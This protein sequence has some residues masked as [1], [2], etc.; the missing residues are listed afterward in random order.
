MRGIKVS[1][2]HGVN[3]MITVCFFCGKDKNEI[4][5]LGRLPGDVA[6][7]MH[8]C[9]DRVPCD[10]CKGYMEQGVILV[11]VKNKTLCENPYRTGKFV[12]IKEEA[13]KELFP[14]IGKSRF[15]YVEDEVW[16]KVG[17]PE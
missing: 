16:A 2:K 3:P 14:T 12:V 6:A 5:L 17:L 11:S 13:A 4:A 8:G 10:E 1:E 7:P 9:I 15:A